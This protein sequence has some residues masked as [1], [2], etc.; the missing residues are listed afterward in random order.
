MEMCVLGPRRHRR[1]CCDRS[2]PVYARIILGPRTDTKSDL[3]AAES[4]AADILAVREARLG[5]THTHQPGELAPVAE[6]TPQIS[7][8]S[9]AAL[10][11]DPRPRVGFAPVLTKFQIPE[12][13]M[14]REHPRPRHPQPLITPHL[15]PRRGWHRPQPSDGPDPS[16]QD[17]SDTS[18]FWAGDTPVNPT[19]QGDAGL[20]VEKLPSPRLSLEHSSGR[21]GGPQSRANP[22][23]H[24]LRDGPPQTFIQQLRPFHGRLSKDAWWKVMLRP[25]VLYSYPAILWSAA[26]YSCSVGWLIVMS[27]SLA[28]IYQ[29]KESYNF[30]PLQTGL[31]YISPF[32]GGLF[33]T[34]VAGKLSDVIVQAMAARNGG[35]Y[36]PEF[37]LVMA[38]PIAISTVLGL[39]GFGW[40]A[41]ERDHWMVPTAFFGI[42]SF[43]CSLGSTTSITFCVDSYR[44]YAGEALVTLNFSKNIL[45][46]LVFSLF[47]THWLSSDGSKM[48]FM[49]T[50]IIHLVVM[51]TTI[52]LFIYGKRLRMWTVRKNMLERTLK[53]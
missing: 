10:R 13:Y 38:L 36:E 33:G 47:F 23:T 1:L 15:L 30:T 22:Y 52:P 29:N 21:Q 20:D 17:K 9:G 53:G 14:Y 34:A 50:G 2:V 32:V 6:A 11:G 28:M 24:R 8:L 43:G 49:W 46:G 18:I 4:D 51:L 37:R 26:V 12:A 45:H 41:E 39:I 35:L 40:S 42:I 31:V 7:P 25:F 3:A 19:L 5:H 44:Q 48:V 16:Q 27:E